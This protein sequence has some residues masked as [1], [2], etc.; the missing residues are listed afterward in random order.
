MSALKLYFLPGA[1]AEEGDD[2]EYERHGDG[3]AEREGKML[4]QLCPE[5]VDYSAFFSV[6][7]MM[8]MAVVVMVVVMIMVVVMVVVM[9]MVVVV[10]MIMV[11]I[12]VMSFVSV[13]MPM[14]AMVMSVM[15]M[16]AGLVLFVEREFLCGVVHVSHI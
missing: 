12:M 4:L 3:D 14:L 15:V 9:I 13:V 16:V 8:T 6:V 10:V 7:V 1:L 11:M 5:S 2:P